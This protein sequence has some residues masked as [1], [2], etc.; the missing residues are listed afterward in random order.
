MDRSNPNRHRFV[1]VETFIAVTSGLIFGASALA[2]NVG[3]RITGRVTDPSGVIVPGVQLAAR[4]ISTNV[5]NT[6]QTNESGY[7]SMQLPIGVYE[8]AASHAGFQSMAQENVTITVGADLEVDFTL[9]LATTRTIVEVQAQASALVAPNDSAVQLTAPPELIKDFPIEVSGNMR[10]AAD[11][12]RLVPGYTGNSFSA[13]LNGGDA[14]D[15]EILIDGSNESP[16]GFGTGNQA[17]MILPSFAIQEFQVISDNVDAQYGRTSTGAIKFV[18]KSGTNGLHGDAFEYVRNQDFDARNFFAPQRGVDR[19]NEFGFELGGPIKRNKTFFYGYYDGYRYTNTN[20]ATFFSLLTPEM[21]VGNFSSAGIPGIYDRATGQQ[22]S[23]SGQL[24]VICQNNLEI[25]SISTYFAGLFPNPNLTGINNNYLGSTTN[26]NNS[27]QYLVKI[28]QNFSNS[29]QLSVSYSWHSNPVGSPY[30]TSFGKTLS[31][32][33]ETQHGD[34]AIVNWN[35]SLSSNKLNH[36]MAAFNIFYFVQLHGGQTSVTGANDLDAKAGLTGGIQPGGQSVI[37]AGP[38]Y[39]GQGSGINKISHSDGEIGD[40][41]TWIRGSHQMQFGFNLTNFYTIGLQLQYN[42]YGTF[43]FAP[44][45]TGQAGNLANTGFVAASYLLG[46]VDNANYGQEPGQAWSMPY[47]AVYAQ[48]KWKVRHNL[49]LSYGL[50]WDYNSPITDRQDRI[51]NF[52]PTLP[53]PD[54]GNIPG[55]LEFAG[56]GPGRAS[57]K[58]FANSWHLGFGPRIGL[59][60]ALSPKTV[61]RAAYGI[62]YDTNSGPAIFLNQQGYFTHAVTGSLDGGVT[63]DFNWQS[64]VPVAPPGPYFVPGFANGGGT[65]YMQPNG[66]REPMVENYNIGLQKELKGGVVIDASYVGTQSHHLLEGVYDYNQLNPSYL[67]QGALLDDDITSAPA[68]ASGVGIPYAGFTGTVAQAERPF[69]QFQGIT[70]SS[71]PVGNA[72]YNSLQIRAQQRLSHG[73]AYLITYTISKDLTDSPGFGGG[74]F[75]GGAQNY[76][77]LRA[78]KAVATWDAPQA[79]TAAYSYDLPAGKG[80]L[81]NLANPVVNKILG[82]WKATGIVTLQRGVPIGLTSELALPGIGGIRPNV[83][84]GVPQFGVHSRASFDPATDVYLNLNAF[85]APPPFSFGDAGPELPNVR[86][87]GTEEWDCALMKRIPITERLSF[88][89]KGEFFNVLN[90]VNFGAP[91]T[92]INNPSFG[93][94][95]SAGNPRLGQLSGTL[96]W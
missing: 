10:N 32:W 61:L 34:R 36:L 4:N 29:S 60:Y 15:Q 52:N 83:V 22:F 3:G 74:A 56:F 86:A 54:T 38:Y 64:G 39:L 84:S 6:A 53:N 92:D 5:S 2:Q 16:V 47:R 25:S 24:N 41:F 71:D 82:D 43:G 35:K 44:A 33:F 40:D 90:T 85:T 78:E 14:F 20:N 93:K 62:M 58:Q 72:T 7:Y 66:A 73:L 37:T 48:D 50:R 59:S 46:L 49:T 30:D 69:P 95:F 96:A 51:A 75:L 31:Q 68:M 88:T 91:V 55:A 18:F 9:Q 80:K 17:Q 87:F 70:L 67:S 1:I 76:Y 27:D 26:T 13:N 94:I 8:V 42:P 12:L 11:F 89:L 21:K 19:Q 65:D 57:V 45:E 63:P 79:F 81:L 28:D 77:N 23:C